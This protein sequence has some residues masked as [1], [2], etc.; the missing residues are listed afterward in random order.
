MSTTRSVR[1]TDLVALVSLDGRVYPNEARTWE[2]LGRRPNGPRLLDSAL[3]P[4]FSFA[5]GRHTWISLQGQTVQ[6]LI[7]ARQRGN[8]TAWEIDCLV[9]ATDD[10]YRIANLFDQVTAAAGASGVTRIFLRLEIG[11]DLMSA[12]RRAGFIAYSEEV[13]YRSDNAE[14]HTETS[15]GLQLEPRKA[16]DTFALYRLYNA[17]VPEPIRRLE[18][19]TYQLWQGAVE[20]GTCGRSKRNVVV[21]RDGEVVGHIRSSRGSDMARVDVMVNPTSH[22]DA[23]RLLSIACGYAGSRRP[24]FCLAPSYATH[25]IT[26]LEQ[27]GF[28]PDSEYALLVKR[29]AL[30]MPA[31]KPVR[32]HAATP[33]P[34]AAG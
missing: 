33:H 24:L 30:P 8:R 21:R 34:M 12:A 25:L 18:A 20:P 22:D 1:P 31:A 11:S 16:A 19:P 29:T 2:S 14:G 5:T 27:S 6:G 7:S 13:L 4:W 23:E 9:A 17:V 15:A 32:A 28:A 10:E 3:R 26:A